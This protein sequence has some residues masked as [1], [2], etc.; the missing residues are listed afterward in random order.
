MA[1]IFGSGD[2]GKLLLKL[3]NAVEIA[4][5][6]KGNPLLKLD[7]MSEEINDFSMTKNKD[8]TNIAFSIND[9]RITIDVQ[10]DIDKK[11]AG[12]PER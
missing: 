2:K 12:K 8:R 1:N 7:L 3:G 11:I 5:H 6:G 4:N 9:L 10:G